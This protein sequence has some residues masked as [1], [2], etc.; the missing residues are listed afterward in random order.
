MGRFRFQYFKYFKFDDFVALTTTTT[1][2][3]L[4]T[5]GKKKSSWFNST[6]NNISKNTVKFN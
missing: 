2:L 3:S 4:G 5:I 1:S 6:G